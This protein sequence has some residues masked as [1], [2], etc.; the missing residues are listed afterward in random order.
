MRIA[1][2]IV[3]GS[4][5]ALTALTTPVLAK[6]SDAAKPIEDSAAASPCYAYQMGA[7]GKW[8]Q[9]PCQE[10]GAAN[11]PPRKTVTRSGME[12]EAH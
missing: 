8:K 3:A 11:H 2:V 5:V 9:L 12:S 6:N 7:D 1:D 10:A 4:V